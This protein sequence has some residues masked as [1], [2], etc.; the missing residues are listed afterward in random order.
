MK[1]L[2]L[3]ALL[4][5]GLS[6]THCRTTEK[7]ETSTVA[8]TSVVANPLPSWNDATAQRI[9]QWISAATDT[10]SPSFIPVADRIA[11]FDNDGTLWP[12]QPYPNQ[13]QFAFN[14][15]RVLAPSHPEWKKDPVINGLLNNDYEPL[16]KAGMKGFGKLMAVTHS[17]MPT[18]SFTYA[19]N[20]WIDTAKDQRF[21]KRYKDLVYQPMLE[22]LDYLRSHQFKTYIVSGGGADFMRPWTE[23]VYGIPPYQVIGSYGEVKYEVK[24]DKPVLTKLAGD[25]YMDDKAGKPV[26]IHRFIGKTP[27]FCAGNSDGDQAMMQYTHGSSYKSFCLIVHHTDEKREYAYDTKTLSGH[28]ETALQEASQKNWLVVNMKTDWKKVFPFE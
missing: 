28:L 2:V 19:V 3:G 7:K 22:L 5:L 4:L 10:A 9:T 26:A 8:G 27:V 12:E 1:T 23:E 14:Y 6:L 17:G 20:Q 25:F 13:L 15:L 18:D 11:V 21:G 16:K 24:N